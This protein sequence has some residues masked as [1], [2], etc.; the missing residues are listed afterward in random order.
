[1]PD[2]KRPERT[3]GS[4]I[5]S[6]GTVVI[7]GGHRTS[8]ATI[9]GKFGGV[10]P[11]TT[12]ACP[13][14]RARLGLRTTFALGDLWDPRIRSMSGLRLEFRCYAC[15]RALSYPLNTLASFIALAILPVV[16]MALVR[17]FG[18]AEWTTSIQTL[19]APYWVGLGALYSFLATP[20]LPQAA[21]RR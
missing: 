10:M 3:D 18:M 16:L 4:R 14:C 11:A 8:R 15:A 2:G 6:H 9:Q 5:F 21:R 20:I 19:I 17:D 12:A 1:M 7:R 13:H